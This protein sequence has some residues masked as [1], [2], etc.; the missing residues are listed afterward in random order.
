LYMGTLM[1]RLEGR[2]VSTCDLNVC[3]H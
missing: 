3:L 2:V 1:E